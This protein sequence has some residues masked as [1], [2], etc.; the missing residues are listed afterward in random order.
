[1]RL[2]EKFRAFAFWLL[3][4]FKGSPIRK[5]YND[6]C[7]TMDNFVFNRPDTESGKNLSKIL[8]HAI[9]TTKFYE[10]IGTPSQLVDFPVINKEIVRKSFDSFCSVKYN[11]SELISV[12]TSGS[13]GTPF[14]VY[15]DRNKKFRNHADTIFFA[16]RAGFR[17][18]ERL[19]YMKIFARQKTRSPLHYWVQNILPVDVIKLNDSQISQLIKQMKSE[20][21]SFNFLGYSSALEL[22]CKYLEKNQTGTVNAKVKSVISISESLNDYTKK[23]SKKFFGVT[24]LS[25]YSNLENGIIAQQ[26]TDGSGRY[27]I[28][29][30]SYVV[31]ILKPDS[32][33]PACSGQP[34]RIVVT[35]L[36]N[37]G[38]PLIR[39][40]TGDI[41]T[42]TQKENSNR[43]IYLTSVE[44]RKLDL[45]YD[46]AGN[47]VSSYIVYKNMW[48]YT[49]IIQ[50]QLIQESQKEYIFKINTEGSF[51]R[52]AQLVNEFKEYLGEDAI[53]NVRYVS[54]IPLLD[55]GKRR[56]I[57][58]NYIKV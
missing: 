42:F 11:E 46:T 55:S 5:H 34:G 49:E 21:S 28:N 51:N 37:Y 39:Y 4:F 2:L 16:S 38:M 36:F 24:A 7:K 32:D 19:I 56:K 14:K 45:L 13:T 44:G 26:E 30:A 53:F 6:I 10:S 29:S 35:D 17:I 20:K 22:V 12:V 31:E 50:Y 40:D 33:E 18:G 57:V 9:S 25:R 47:L 43:N 27:L 1:M 15:H 41:G 48:Q 52:E 8:S 23:T 3:D 58:N 54:E